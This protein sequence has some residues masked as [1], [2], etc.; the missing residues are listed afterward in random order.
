MFR[1]ATYSVILFLIHSQNILANHDVEMASN[2]FEQALTKLY[3]KPGFVHRLDTGRFNVGAGKPIKISNLNFNEDASVPRICE[4]FMEKHMGD[5][6]RDGIVDESDVAL[7][8]RLATGLDLSE[9]R[10]KYQLQTFYRADLNSDGVISNI[11]IQMASTKL[12]DPIS[13]VKLDSSLV[14]SYLCPAFNN[15]YLR[16][17]TWIPLSDD[18]YI[19]HLKDD[20]NVSLQ[21]LSGSSLETNG[22]TEISLN[23]NLVA[24]DVNN[25]KNCVVTMG[26]GVA[27][28]GVTVFP[29]APMTKL[30]D[31]TWIEL[32]LKKAQLEKP[33]SSR[34]PGP[35]DPKTITD[36]RGNALKLTYNEAINACAAK[37]FRLMSARE[38]ASL[39]FQNKIVEADS[40]SVLQFKITDTYIQSFVQGA[41]GIF[42]ADGSQVD[43]FV[44]SPLL[45]PIYPK[46][47]AS[48]EKIWTSTN[49]PS[50]TNNQ[51]YV[52]DG[53]N[54]NFTLYGNKTT[55]RFAAICIGSTR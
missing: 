24:V 3:P 6:N 18:R 42:K 45:L 8:R 1:F 39:V 27:S 32:Q 48:G 10:K 19:I 29:V 33:V 16:E 46:G 55:D 34:L 11:D 9:P 26:H 41:Y 28:D 7:I 52:Y 36:G 53:P 47:I 14:R 5:L 44:I 35:Y 22:L 21:F 49:V 50:V 54:A 2:C 31:F 17:N 43:F 20:G 30:Q 37:G 12:A 15:G 51:V 23:P 13:K 40:N 4:S 38:V 25:L